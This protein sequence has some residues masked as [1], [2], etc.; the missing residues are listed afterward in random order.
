LPFTITIERIPRLTR[1]TLG[2]LIIR[3][4]EPERQMAC[5][6]CHGQAAGM[7][8]L[9][10]GRALCQSCYGFARMGIRR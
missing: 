2:S 9:W 6:D 10:R 1:E 7:L 4:E 5:Y 8:H 3:L